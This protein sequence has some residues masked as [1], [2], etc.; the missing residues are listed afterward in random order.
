MSVPTTCFYCGTELDYKPSSPNQLEPGKPLIKWICSRCWNKRH[1]GPLRKI[2]WDKP[3][4]EYYL[5]DE[6]GKAWLLA[7]MDE[8]EDGDLITIPEVPEDIIEVATH[9]L[10]EP[11]I[12]VYDP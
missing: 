5:I 12:Q 9:K 4:D 6:D 10:P 7:R 2:V 11:K 1:K 3:F 8:D